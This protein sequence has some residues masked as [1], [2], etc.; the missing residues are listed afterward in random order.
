MTYICKSQPT[1]LLSMTNLLITSTRC[2]IFLFLLLKSDFLYYHLLIRNSFHRNRDLR[3]SPTLSLFYLHIIFISATLYLIL[4]NTTLYF[5]YIFIKIIF[6]LF[7]FNFFFSFL[8][9]C[10]PPQSTEIGK[11]LRIWEGRG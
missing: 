4:F 1:F 7:Y 6:L 3:A 2:D 8:I 11:R 9:P 5:I 10:L